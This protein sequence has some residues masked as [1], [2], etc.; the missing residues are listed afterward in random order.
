MPDRTVTESTTPHCAV[1]V[2][3]L[4][5]TH[6]PHPSTRK[7]ALPSIINTSS[8]SFVNP[9]FQQQEC[10]EKK[11]PLGKLALLIFSEAH[12]AFFLFERVGSPLPL[13]FDCSLLCGK[14]ET[15]RHVA[16]QMYRRAE[17]IWGTIFLMFLQVFRFEE[18]N[19]DNIN[20]SVQRFSEPAFSPFGKYGEHIGQFTSPL[21]GSQNKN[22][23]P[24]L[25]IPVDQQLLWTQNNILLL[26]FV[27]R[28]QF[29]RAIAEL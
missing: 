7:T 13:W 10:A 22:H 5:A 26:E 21:Q 19:T 2:S 16:K 14:T 29:R 9:M 17:S 23:C 3:F 24:Y 25:H 4:P 15:L 27:S 6:T 20:L 11:S 8:Q 12:T 18:K 28:Q 1:A